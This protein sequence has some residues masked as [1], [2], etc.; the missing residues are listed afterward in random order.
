MSLLFSVVICLLQGIY[1]KLNDLV[2]VRWLTKDCVE[3]AL[4][5]IRVKRLIL[6]GR[7]HGEL[8]RS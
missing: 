7:E 8:W 5:S 3:P 1:H 4:E 6:A 2:L